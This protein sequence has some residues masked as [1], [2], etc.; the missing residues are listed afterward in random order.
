MDSIPHHVLRDH[1][2]PS[3]SSSPQKLFYQVKEDIISTIGPGYLEY[4]S[5]LP[6]VGHQVAQSLSVD[7]QVERSSV[8]LSY[9]PDTQIL[10][11][12]MPTIFHN[13]HLSWVN[14]ELMDAA[15]SGFFTP[16]ERGFSG[17]DNFPAPYQNIYKEP[18]CFIRPRGAAFPTI[19]FEVGYSQTY[20]QLTADKDLWFTAA[21]T[22]N[23]VILIKWS[24]ISGNR[25]KGFM[26]LWRRG[27]P[28]P[29]RIDIFPAPPPGSPPQ[30]I[31]F[32]R[33]DLYAGGAVPAGRN[34]NEAWTWQIDTL[35]EMADQDIRLEGNLP[36]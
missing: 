22:V 3:A 33:G 13:S 8:T 28:N 24:L 29:Q 6:E 1:H 35:R 36:A 26:E 34:A 19:V 9:N 16:Q 23:V 10:S 17:F 18:D 4:T 32:Y 21:P 30:T 5:V 25:V 14:Q 2:S 15:A 27:T 31:D 20:S 7:P 12:T 11:V